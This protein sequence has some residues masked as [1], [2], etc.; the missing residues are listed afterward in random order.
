MATSFSVLRLDA[1]GAILEQDI[2]L[3]ESGDIAL[4]TGLAELRER[5][6]CRL[7]MLRGEDIFDRSQGLPLTGQIL[8]RPFSNSLAASVISAEILQVPEVTAVEEIE[9]RV[10]DRRLQYTAARI[11][12]IFGELTVKIG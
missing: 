12:S 10:V 6:T 5:V 1:D 8:Q 3:N 9:V 2:Y 4:V 7:L 11:T